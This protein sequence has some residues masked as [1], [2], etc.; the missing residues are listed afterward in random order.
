MGQ[1]EGA[2]ASA[3]VGLASS[4]EPA[5]DLEELSISYVLHTYRAVNA[6]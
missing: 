1:L 6:K 4:A 5:S 2:G 3:T